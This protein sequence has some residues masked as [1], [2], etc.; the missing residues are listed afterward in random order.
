MNIWIERGECFE[1]KLYTDKNNKLPIT[2]KTLR[3]EER[4]TVPGKS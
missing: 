4:L 3:F 2:I 1:K